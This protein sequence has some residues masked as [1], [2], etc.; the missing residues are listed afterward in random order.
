MQ[1]SEECDTASSGSAILAVDIDDVLAQFMPALIRFHNDSYGSQLTMDD[2]HSYDFH[3]VW[4]GSPSECQDKMDAFFDSHYFVDGIEPMQGSRDTL[5]ALKRLGYE[6]HIVTSRQ[7]KVAEHTMTWI[8]KYYDNVFSD[9]HM[10]NH[11]ARTG[12]HRSKS[13]IC[14]DI[15][16]KLL[17]DD[18]SRYANECAAAGIPVIL[19]GNY[20]WNTDEVTSSVPCI[21]RCASWSTVLETVQQLLHHDHHC[22]A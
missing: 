17:I 22:T 20:A 5:E 2:F 11:Y 7:Y 14:K 19:Y 6:L 21:R 3:R 10:G 13:Q 16:A 15:G 9:V 8:R 4:G 1:Q 18:S 12:T